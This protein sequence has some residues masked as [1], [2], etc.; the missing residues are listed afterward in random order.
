MISKM[1]ALGYRN[2]FF[3]PQSQTG[4]HVTFITIRQV[5]KKNGQTFITVPGVDKILIPALDLDGKA[6]QENGRVK[7]VEA[8]IAYIPGAPSIFVDE[9]MEMTG[10]KEE[11][12]VLAEA[13]DISI[14]DGVLRVPRHEI[15]KIA[16][17]RA[18]G[19]NRDCKNNP[20]G[21]PTFREWNQ[22]IEAKMRLD[23]VVPRFDV[24]SRITHMIQEKQ[25]TALWLIYSVLENQPVAVAKQVVDLNI[26]QLHLLKKADTQPELIVKA[27]EDESYQDRMIILQAF[28]TGELVEDINGNVKTIDGKQV[29]FV[30]R[31][32]SQVDAVHASISKEEMQALRQRI[33]T[34][35]QRQMVADAKENA[36]IKSLEQEIE[37]L[38]SIQAIGKNVD[39][40]KAADGVYDAVTLEDAKAF[41]LGLIEKNVITKQI[42]WLGGDIL[43]NIEY[44]KDNK[45]SIDTLSEFLHKNP[46]QLK[47]MNQQLAEV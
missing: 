17:M 25:H 11:E 8:K 27:L 22:A 29:S 14:F 46:D 41:V 40:N 44:C 47:L 5:N 39:L 7:L 31:G 20:S 13:Q 32:A 26:M 43:P 9:I 19:R 12:K 1:K 15:N 42:K 4:E 6:I 37:R 24:T 45:W 38:K 23:S 10:R 34:I 36:K 30:A 28:Y 18:T 3:D 16:F 21:F 33:G 2:D 35:F